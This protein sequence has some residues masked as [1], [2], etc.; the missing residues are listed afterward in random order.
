[1]YSEV[2]SPVKEF[3]YLK[4]R[5]LR[6][7]GQEID[8]INSKYRI[9]PFEQPFIESVESNLKAGRPAKR[10]LKSIFTRVQALDSKVNELRLYRVE[11]DWD[12]YKDFRLL[13]SKDSSWSPKFVMMDYVNDSDK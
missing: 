11:Y 10:I 8:F 7:S 12:K 5:V 13:R 2:F 3:T 1:M 4:F 9:F 6:K